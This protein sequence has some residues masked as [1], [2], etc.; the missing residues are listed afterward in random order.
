MR[1]LCSDIMIAAAAVT[2]DSCWCVTVAQQLACQM[3]AA[4]MLT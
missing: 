3:Q 1:L 4:G 2:Y